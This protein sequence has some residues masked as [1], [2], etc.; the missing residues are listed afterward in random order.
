[1]QVSQLYGKHHSNSPHK[2]IYVYPIKSMRPTTLT[3]AKLTCNGLPYDRTFMLLKVKPDGQLQNMHIDKFPK[4]SLFLTD[5]EFPSSHQT[6]GEN[7][8]GDVEQDDKGWI[9]VTYKNSA[10]PHPEAGVGNTLRIPL[11]PETSNL[12][13]FEV[14]MHRSPTTAYDMGVEYS[15]WFSAWLGFKI[16]FAY[17]GEHRRL[18]LGNFASTDTNGGWMSA[19]SSM[20]PIPGLARTNDASKVLTFADMAPYLVVSQTS[21]DNVSSRLPPDEP[22][23]ITKFRPNIVLAGAPTAFDEDY[24]AE[25]V[26]GE[27]VEVQ[28]RNNCVRCMSLNVDFD[29][30]APHKGE[31]GTVLKKLMKDRRVDK[32]SKYSPVFGRYGFLHREKGA[33][34][35]VIRVGDAV[36][37]SKVNAERT[38]LGEFPVYLS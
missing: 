5:I 23:D 38:T 24:W 30:G 10:G 35:P 9:T 7:T 22:M 18:A 31:S 4:L 8:N 2:Q 36:K 6:N 26:I 37:V 1:M 21:V 14:M 28:L 13:Q 34:E 16:V 17:I 25:L 29:T 33:S 12:K 3:S 27:D 19:I 32:G 15:S 11:K 20:V